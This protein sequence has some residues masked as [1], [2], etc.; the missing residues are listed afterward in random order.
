MPE[1]CVYHPCAL[2]PPPSFYPSPLW[3]RSSGTS[4]DISAGCPGKASLF[5]GSPLCFSTKIV[6]KQSEEALT[7]LSH[8]SP[9]L[10]NN[11]LSPGFITG[12]MHLA[13]LICRRNGTQQLAWKLMCSAALD[14][15]SQ[16]QRALEKCPVS[17]L[18]NRC[19]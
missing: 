5:P 18:G 8:K 13:V 14:K 6:C 3:F 1:S 9:G 11:S 10:E 19:L 15:L 7:L 17:Y 16:T 2:R 4:K 12:E